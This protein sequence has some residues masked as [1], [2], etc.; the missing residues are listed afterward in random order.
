LRHFGHALSQPI[1]Q[2]TLRF[3]DGGGEDDSPIVFSGYNASNQLL[4]TLN[5]TYGSSESTGAT[6]SG[7]FA[8]FDQISGR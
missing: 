4:G 2:I 5:G 7:S 3:G 8:E 6:V 1:T